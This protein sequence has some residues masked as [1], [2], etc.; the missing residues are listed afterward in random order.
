MFSWFFSFFKILFI[1]LRVTASM[2]KVE[3]GWAEGEGEVDSPLSRELMWGLI[4]GLWH[5]DLSRRQ[6]LT[7]ELPKCPHCR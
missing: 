2:N 1:Y 5:H 6:M 3:G 7:T 4:P